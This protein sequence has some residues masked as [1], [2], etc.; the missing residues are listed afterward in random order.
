[1]R[2]LIVFLLLFNS[3]VFA[4][5]LPL[6]GVQYLRPIQSASC[7][8]LK[9]REL[10]R[11]KV[12]REL[13]YLN[14]LAKQGKSTALLLAN[15]LL[16]NKLFMPN[17][18]WRDQSARVVVQLNIPEGVVS[19]IAASG[20][21]NLYLAI[22]GP[23]FV[24]Q[25]FAYQIPPEMSVS[26][27]MAAKTMQIEYLTYLNVICLGDKLVPPQVEWFPAPEAPARF[28]TWDWVR[29]LLMM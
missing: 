27:D 2:F 24:W 19:E 29:S 15:N 28:N 8:L 22:H 3:E 21:G 14:K 6:T 26:V 13:E 18:T 23:G 9:Q 11:E 17:E 12:I 1:M 5:I 16:L 25:S 20:V 7:G 10:E 4:E